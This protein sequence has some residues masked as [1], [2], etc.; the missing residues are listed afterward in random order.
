MSEKIGKR[1]EKQ[2][3][4]K[5]RKQ[6]YQVLNINSKGFPDLIVLDGNTIKF[7]VE[8]KGGKHRVHH[9]QMK[10]HQKLETMGFTVKIEQV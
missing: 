8:V 3:A 4:N 2:V 10:T 7:F 5:Y 6:G 1:N 9:F